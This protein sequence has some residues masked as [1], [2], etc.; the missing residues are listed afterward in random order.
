[1]KKGDLFLCIDGQCKGRFF[2]FEN[3]TTYKTIKAYRTICEKK[4]KLYLYDYKVVPATNLH[5]ILYS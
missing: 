5:K 2:K 3:R 1:M 4:E